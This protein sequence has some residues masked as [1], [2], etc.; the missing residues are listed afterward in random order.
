MNF[1]YL[2]M[3]HTCIL[4][5]RNGQSVTFEYF[6]WYHYYTISVYVVFFMIWSD[7]LNIL[8]SL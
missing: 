3:T 6:V 2:K 5:V 7:I 4:S 1:K 8:L